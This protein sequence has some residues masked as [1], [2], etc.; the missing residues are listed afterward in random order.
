MNEAETRAELIDPALK[1]AGWG[2]VE[3]SRVRR[4][5]I[6]PGR[7][8]GSGR[9]ASAEWADYVLEYKGEKLGV[10]EAKKRDDPDTEGIGQAKKY[11]KKLEIRYAYS[12]NG[13]GIYQV[14]MR[15]GQEGYISAYPTPEALWTATFATENEWRDRF[16]DIPF[17]SRSGTWDARYYQHIAIKHVLD[18]ISEGRDRHSANDGHRHRQNL[19]R[20]PAHL[21]ALS[22]PMEPQP[23]AQPPPAH[24]LP[25][26]PQHLG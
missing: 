16:A 14:D 23:P 2:V 19:R 1:S 21:E 12:T 9:R 25:S 15:T 7:L 26:R 11:A 24:P 13:K 22:K 8:L 6:V 18:A 17:E 20:L 3:G 5:M 4:E 10:I